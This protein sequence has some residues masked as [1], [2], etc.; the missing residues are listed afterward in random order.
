MS[1][2]R[3][4]SLLTL[5]A[6][7]LSAPL[8]A[9]PVTA[10]SAYDA[11]DWKTCASLYGQAADRPKPAGGAAYNAACCLAMA[12]EIDAAFE[13]LSRTDPEV[14]PGVAHLKEDTDLAA[15]RA[16]SRWQAL[17]DKLQAALR[18]R[19]RY[20]DMPLRRELAARVEKDQD[21][22]NRWI[23]NTDDAVLGEQLTQVDRDNTTWLKGVVK[24]QGWPP[25]SKVGREGAQ[26]AWLLVQHAD[27]DPAFQEEALSL[28]QAQVVKGE[29]SGRLLAYLTDRVRLA[30]NKPQVYGTQFH[31]TVDG[32]LEPLQME[33]P[34]HV[35]E[36]RAAVGLESMQEYREQMAD[37][38]RPGKD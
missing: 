23:Q 20:Y 1:S 14:L 29:A 38:Y 3:L 24:A 18:A 2:H 7:V 33:D 37:S 8:H 22:R 35:D 32:K 25:I 12:G 26:A 21:L 6:V 31:R 28:M 27:L 9:A 15:L 4:A 30:Q 17:L 16:D 10:Q 34:A 11:K 36:R 13:R 19:E 5:L